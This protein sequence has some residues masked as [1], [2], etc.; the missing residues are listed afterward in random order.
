MK[1]ACTY[2]LGI[3]KIKDCFC[4]ACIAI[5]ENDSRIYEEK[6]PENSPTFQEI[7]TQMRINVDILK[8]EISDHCDK[9]IERFKNEITNLLPKSTNS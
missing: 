8:K 6:I 5:R 2:S 3:T 4:L 1:V 7:S 9:E